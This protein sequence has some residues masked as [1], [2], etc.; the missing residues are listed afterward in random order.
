M[1][2]LIGDSGLIGSTLKESINFDLTFNSKNISDFSK[3]VPQKDCELYLSCLPAEKWK[4]NLNPKEDV[5]NLLLIYYKIAIKTYSKVIL[6]STIDIYNSLE[7]GSDETVFPSMHNPLNNYGS[8]RYL[9]ERLILDK[10]PS[11]DIKVF[12][13][14]ALYSNKIKKNI[15]YDL[16]N[17]NNTDKIKVNS[18][19]QWY[20]LNNLVFDVEKYCE[21][22]PKENIF[23]MFTEPIH[24]TRIAG[25]FSNYVPSTVE[26]GAYYD[27]KTKFSKSGYIDTAEN[28]LKDIEKFVYEYR[29]QQSSTRR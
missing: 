7:N 25:M 21:E 15:L 5:R 12:R 13:L 3:M 26:A 19:Y 18:S 22:F 24:T 16:L 17:D 9:F 27:Y 28:V 1:K 23:N 11:N 6:F 14:P 10:V 29:N 8:N 20:N 2:V 4:V